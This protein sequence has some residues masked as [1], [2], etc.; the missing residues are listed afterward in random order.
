VT[1]PFRLL[2]Q[3]ADDETGL[4]S[5]RFRFFDPEVGRWC[6]PDPLGL[7]GG[8]DLHGFD[9]TPTVD[10][11]PLGLSTTGN[12]H[13]TPVSSG[14]SRAPSVGTPNSIYEQTAPS[15][16]VRS[17]TFYDENGRTFARQDFDHSHGGMRPHEHLRSFDRNGRPITSETVRPVPDGYDT[18]PTPP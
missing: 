14:L 16:E 12:P 7:A 1:S 11:D 9:G 18:T 13:P 15:G 3:Y 4:T 8:L 17:R 2:G 5:T 6:S 10:V